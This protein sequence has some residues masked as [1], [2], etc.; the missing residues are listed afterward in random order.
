MLGEQ[1]VRLL[2]SELADDGQMHP[3]MAGLIYRLEPDAVCVAAS[4][5]GLRVRQ[6]LNGD[7]ASVMSSLRLGDRFVT[8]A[9]RLEEARGY[10]ATYTPLGIKGKCSS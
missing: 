3:F 1:R 5:G 2:S 4:G 7:G 10:R 8:P 9:T 6:V